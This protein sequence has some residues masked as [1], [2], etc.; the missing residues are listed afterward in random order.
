MIRHEKIHDIRHQESPDWTILKDFR[1]LE[2]HTSFPKIC[3][4]CDSPL[5]HSNCNFDPFPVLL[6]AYTP[7]QTIRH[8]TIHYMSHQECTDWTILKDFRPLEPHTSFPKICG[9]CYS[10]LLHSNCNFDPFPILLDAYT[11]SLTIRHEKIHDI[12][13]QE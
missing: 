11:P 6:D 13:H 9:N 5:L 3:G 10:Q 7:S 4:N 1:P 8:E 2:Q 12:R